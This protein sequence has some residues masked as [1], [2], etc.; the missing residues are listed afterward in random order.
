MSYRKLELV[1]F[2]VIVDLIDLWFSLRL[3]LMVG[4]LYSM[5]FEG[6]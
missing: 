1:Y 3:R 5:I 2:L 4:C 6:N